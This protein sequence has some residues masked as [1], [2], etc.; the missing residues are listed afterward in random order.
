MDLRYWVCNALTGEMVQQVNLEGASSFSS[1]LGGGQFSANL[2]LSLLTR[3]RT[4]PDW[5]AIRT[6]V[7]NVTTGRHSLLVTAGTLLLGEWWIWSQASEVAGWSLPITGFEFEGYPAYRRIETDFRYGTP[8]DTLHIARDVL[9]GAYRHRQ[10][11]MNMTVPTVASGVMR[12]LDRRKDTQQYGDVIDD[13]A[14]ADGFEWRVIP[15]AQW[16]VNAVT[17]VTRRVE[18]GAPELVQETNFLLDMNGPGSR[19]SNVTS[20]SRRRNM[21]LL[22]SSRHVWGAGEGAKQKRATSFDGTYPGRGYPIRSDVVEMPDETSQTRLQ[23]AA[24]AGIA[25]GSRLFEP[26][27]ARVTIEK[28]GRQWPRVGDI[29][30]LEIEPTPAL[31]YGAHGRHRIGEVSFSPTGAQVHELSVLA[32]GQEV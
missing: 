9:Q 10:P 5:P 28:L 20:V 12:T 23:A 3:D 17:G 11:S 31:P 8:T 14:E 29:A 21:D 7:D 27:S 30:T 16:A 25:G 19:A 24:D 13:I 32:L 1:R 2:S 18:F 4:Q 15:E 26:L 6:L 22:L